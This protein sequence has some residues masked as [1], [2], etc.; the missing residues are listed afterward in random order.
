MAEGIAFA[1]IL[2]ARLITR[3]FLLSGNG[4][5]S[6]LNA[7]GLGFLGYAGNE[8]IENGRTQENRRICRR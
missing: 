7:L 3:S 1:P 2:G 5:G 8:V 4:F 6:R